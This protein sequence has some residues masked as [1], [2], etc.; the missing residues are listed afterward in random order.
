[1]R[2]K[3]LTLHFEKAQMGFNQALS[4]LEQEKVALE[5]KLRR[6]DEEK[7]QIKELNDYEM[8]VKVNELKMGSEREKEEHRKELQKM[9]E[10]Y[11]KT[12]QEMK[13]T[14]ENVQ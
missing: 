7:M 8:L 14:F 6:V 13:L 11:D 9:K 2:L 12:I 4:D 1:L 10:N 3:E 5:T